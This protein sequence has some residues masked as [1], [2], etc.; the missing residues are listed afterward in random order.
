MR[1]VMAT[2]INGQDLEDLIKQHVPDI[3]NDWEIAAAVEASNSESREYT[4]EKTAL[5]MKDR[6][7]EGVHDYVSHLCFLGFIPK[8]AVVVDY[9]W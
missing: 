5:D 2:F 1:T 6:K 8:G 9:S 7:W 4:A 3:E